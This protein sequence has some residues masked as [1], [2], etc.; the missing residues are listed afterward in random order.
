[1]VDRR[2]R[3]IEKKRKKR[4]VVRQQARLVRDQQSQRLVASAGRA[5]F[6]PCALSNGWDSDEQPPSLVTVVV[7]RV[8]GNGSLLP[9]VAL[10]DRTCLGIKNGFLADPMHPSELDDWLE[11]TFTAHGG[12]EACEPQVAQSIVFHA[13]DYAERLGFRAHPD[14]EL[15]LFE[16]RPEVLL[17]TPWHAAERP[18]YITGPHDNVAAIINRLTESVGVD[19][20][21][22]AHMGSLLD[23]DESD[24]DSDDELE[25]PR[26]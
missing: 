12:W 21:D 13:L 19:G 3:K 8:L 9:S 4:K 1:M 16:P 23:L 11:D 5:P 18:I 24:S 22:V 26:G 15:T 2:Q 20:F 25:L 6:G 14:A 17:P 7:T 10:V